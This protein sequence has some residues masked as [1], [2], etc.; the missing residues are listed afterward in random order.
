MD[1]ILSPLPQTAPPDTFSTVPQPPLSITTS[2]SRR[3]PF[4]PNRQ[5]ETCLLVR[6]RSPLSCVTPPPRG[7][8]PADPAGRRCKKP[9]QRKYRE[10]INTRRRSPTTPQHYTHYC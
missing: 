5:P 3:Y 4:V 8:A 7:R 10:K 6:I 1:I 2:P 9:V